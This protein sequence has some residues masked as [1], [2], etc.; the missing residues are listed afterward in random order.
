MSAFYD[1]RL[2]STRVNLP[3]SII[4]SS[5]E[6]AEIVWN[7]KLVDLPSQYD[8]K[9]SILANLGRENRFYIRFIRFIFIHARTRERM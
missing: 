2:V 5:S 8:Q 3:G 4:V 7:R 6:P 9:S 1:S